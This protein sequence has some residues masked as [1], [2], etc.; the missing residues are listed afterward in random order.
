MVSLHSGRVPVLL[1]IGVLLFTAHASTTSIYQMTLTDA[2]RKEILSILFERELVVAKQKELVILLS[3]LTDTKWPLDLPGIRFKK[4]NYGEEKQVSEYYELSVNKIDRNY[5]EVW[6]SKG[7]YCKKSGESYRFRKENGKWVANPHRSFQSFGGS[8]SCPACELG[9][10]SGH[11]AKPGTVEAKEPPK[12]LVLTGKVLAT[13]CKRFEE[14][15]ILCELDLSLDFVNLGKE[16]IIILQPNGAYDFWHGATNLA[17]SKA[18][19]EAYNYVYSHGAWPS[20]YRWEMYRVLAEKLDQ[21]TPPANVTRIIAPSES[22]NYKTTVRLK[23][24]EEKTCNYSMGVEIGWKEIKKLTSPVWMEVSFEMWPTNVENFRSDLGEQL[25]K[26][27]K[28]HGILYLEERHHRRSF[29]SVSSEPIELDFQQ[30]ELP[31]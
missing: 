25:R 26:R 29:A 4:L 11:K 24:N 15:D 8:G 14:K 13:R 22:W 3:P 5:V 19:A 16:P 31:L 7:N 28:Q 2:D 1:I 30:V 20:V 18:D 21:A 6:F 27:W 9:S 17:L 12:T 10:G 23:L